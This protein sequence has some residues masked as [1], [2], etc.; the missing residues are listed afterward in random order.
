RIR[1]NTKVDRVEWHEES[2][3]YTL[4]TATGET[5]EFDFIVSSVGLLNVPRYPDWPGL[6]EFEGISFHTSRWEHEHDL[7]GKSVAIVGTG[8]T[9]VQ[10]APA[11]AP[12]V[13]DLTVYQREPGWIEPKN[14]RAYTPRE[15]WVYRHVPFAQRAHRL[16]ML[17]K[18]NHRFK[19]YD[20]RSR[21][22]RKMQAL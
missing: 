15:R 3:T 20:T 4:E 21:M 11:L 7:R 6:E 14:E 5:H 1:L 9:A 17:A 22:Q 16:L 19:A 18:A 8:S 13:G 10:V 2:S 12:V